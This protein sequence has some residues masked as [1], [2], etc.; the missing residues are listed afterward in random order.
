MTGMGED[1]TQDILQEMAREKMSDA[2]RHSEERN[3]L[4]LMGTNDGFWDYDITSEELYLSPRLLEMVG[5]FSHRVTPNLED[6]QELVHPED[7]AILLKIIQEHLAGESRE[8]KIEFR[9]RSPEGVYLWMLGKGR[10]TKDEGH[11]LRVSGSLS[12]IT[13]RKQA[14]GLL[15]GVLDS[16]PNGVMALQ[17]IRNTA[18][19]IE[20]FEIQ[21]VNRPIEIQAQMSAA[22]LV[23]K[24]I[25]EVL[26]GKHEKSV[27]ELFKQ[28][29]E[30]QK[31][32]KMEF[33][34]EYELA[35]G[36]WFMV[37][38][39]PTEDGVTATFTRIT[40][41][42]ETERQLRLLSLVAS[43]TDNGVIITNPEGQTEWINEEFSRLLSFDIR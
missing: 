38:A 6:L 1:V 29:M 24:R 16:S 9:M 25:R 28:V 35:A 17:A 43:K 7:L 4:L 21:L 27:I 37:I 40:K 30:A 19:K 31:S 36:D 12:D 2:L 13:E 23:G 8:I 20:D 26:P 18:R 10:L 15:A 32:M 14:E 41:Q 42:K 34:Y 33:Y 39:V 5:I 11:S 3:S 22:Q